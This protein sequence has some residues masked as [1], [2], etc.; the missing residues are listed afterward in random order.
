MALENVLRTRF[1]VT[2]VFVCDDGQ[3]AVDHLSHGTPFGLALVDLNMPGIAN[4]SLLDSIKDTQPQI[5]L[6]V[7]SA[8]K[9]REDILMTLSAGAHGF[10]NKGLGIL[11]M[12]K[13][14]GQIAQGVI[15]VPPF[16]PHSMEIDE[17]PKAAGEKSHIDFE[18][19]TWRQQDVLRLIVEG[20]SNKSIAQILDISSSTVK[21]HLATIFTAL[22][23][24]NRVEAAMIASRMINLTK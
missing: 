2:N 9:S 18:A 22:G 15:Y 5:R 1:G 10:I 14:L 24:S 19:L 3:A 7:L 16:M 20:H 17:P 21:F 8:S 11:E 4:R 13:A 6:V 12:E 23:A